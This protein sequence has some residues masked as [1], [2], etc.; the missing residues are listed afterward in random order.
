MDRRE[1]MTM[2]LNGNRL[3]SINDGRKGGFLEERG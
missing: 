3:E 2:L 1:E